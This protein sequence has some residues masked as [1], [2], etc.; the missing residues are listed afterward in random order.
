VLNNDLFE[1]VRLAIK[2]YLEKKGMSKDTI[3]KHNGAVNRIKSYFLMN[4]LQKYDS[5][6]TN[7]YRNDLE[8]ACVYDEINYITKRKLTRVSHMIDDFY[9]NREFK[10]KYFNERNFK[11]PI[12]QDNKE[13]LDD[14]INY[15]KISKNSLSGYKSSVRKLLFYFE[16]SQLIDLAMVDEN[17]IFDFFIA[18]AHEHR[19]SM[20]NIQCATK[21]FM[22]YLNEKNLNNKKITDFLAHKTAKSQRK[23]LFPLSD[24]VLG[25]L[26]SAIDLET[27][28]G[29]RDYAILTLAEYTGMRAIDIA[30][31]KLDDIDFKN[32]TI[33]FIQHKTS[34]ENKLPLNKNLVKALVGY[35]KVRPSS[36]ACE[37][38]LF[39]TVV[40]PFRKLNDK[41]SVRNIM[42]KYLRIV[43]VELNASSGNSFHGFRRRLGVKLLESD[44]N[45]EMIAQILGHKNIHTLKHYLSFDT[46][47]MRCC[48]LGLEMIPVYSGV[49]L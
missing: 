43:G 31:L 25:K 24:D 27:V 49:Y 46:E 42:N 15:L 44:A 30:N 29:K 18:I 16:K 34:Y 40:P 22:T 39:L 48:A 14:F 9:N 47:K 3:Y 32:Y 45:I 33:V 41:S 37:N 35:L 17:F 7:L 21:S 2:I 23:V 1:D 5:N 6:L 36:N 12:N 8:N 26:L 11:Y 28:M 13:L 38:H 10:D 20:N 4:G 19:G